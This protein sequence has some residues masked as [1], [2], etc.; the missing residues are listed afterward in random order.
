V[1]CR[2]CGE[3]VRPVLSGTDIHWKVKEWVCSECGPVKTQVLVDG[4]VER[5]WVKK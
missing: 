2:F 5:T 3:L 4:K 1:K